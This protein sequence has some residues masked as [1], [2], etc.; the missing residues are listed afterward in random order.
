[1]EVAP[2]HRIV[3][4]PPVK[5]RRPAMSTN[6]FRSLT[7]EL[8]TGGNGPLAAHRTTVRKLRLRAAA[9]VA[10]AVVGITLAPIATVLADEGDQSRPGTPIVRDY[11]SAAPPNRV[12]RP[13]YPARG[14][15]TVHGTYQNPR[16][17]VPQSD[18]HPGRHSPRGN[19]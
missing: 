8:T 7:D 14:G 4:L 16:S 13:L 2:K 11:P 6:V 18:G 12:T 1:M 17:H 3:D 9:A 5:T 15:Q 19:C 10:L